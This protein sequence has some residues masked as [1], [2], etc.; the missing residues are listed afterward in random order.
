MV[1]WIIFKNHHMKVGLT[2][3]R[4]TMTLRTLTI[5]GCG[6]YFLF[7]IFFLIMCEDPHKSEFIE[8]ALG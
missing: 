2:L 3:T 7:F 1:T 6:F 4:D 8:I 5:V